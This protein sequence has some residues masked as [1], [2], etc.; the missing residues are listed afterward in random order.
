MCKPKLNIPNNK[1]IFSVME[2]LPT[3]EEEAPPPEPE[4]IFVKVV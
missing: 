4:I 1:Y 2:T 3:T